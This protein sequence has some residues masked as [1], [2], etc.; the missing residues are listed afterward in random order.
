MSNQTQKSQGELINQ[1]SKSRRTQKVW[2]AGEQVTIEK[3]A[4]ITMPK[5]Q[6]P[7][8]SHLSPIERLTAARKLAE[9]HKLAADN[10]APIVAP[11]KGKVWDFLEPDESTKRIKAMIAEMEAATKDNDE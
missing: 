8:L 11:I 10:S 4:P 6:Q 1:L 2:Q 9:K 3:T 5:A 7:D